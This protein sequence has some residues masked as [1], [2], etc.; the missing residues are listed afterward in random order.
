MTAYHLKP[1]ILPFPPFNEEKEK[2]RKVLEEVRARRKIIYTNFY[3]K[4]LLQASNDL[5][6][7]A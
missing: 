7:I 6:T 4:M 3:K 2:R 5:A 1:A